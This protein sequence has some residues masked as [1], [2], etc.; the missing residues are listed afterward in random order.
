M[1]TK[2]GQNRVAVCCTGGRYINPGR[3]LSILPNRQFCLK[4]K[5]QHDTRKCCSFSTYPSRGLSAPE[6]V[7]YLQF[8][9]SSGIFVYLNVS[10]P[11]RLALILILVRSARCDL[12]GTRSIYGSFLKH[13]F[14]CELE[15]QAATQPL[16]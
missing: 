1:T 12:L 6:G 2:V 13:P 14:I 10:I 11:R 4:E 16:F 9:F 8:L 15:F 7:Q 5:L 3:I